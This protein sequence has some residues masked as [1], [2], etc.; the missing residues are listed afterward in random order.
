MLAAV[1]GDTTF[2]VLKAAHVLAASREIAAGAD[3][4]WHRSS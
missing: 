3:K 4:A 2:D 1:F